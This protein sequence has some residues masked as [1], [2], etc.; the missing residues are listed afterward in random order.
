M[1]SR[2]LLDLLED[3]DWHS[4]T[5]LAE[6]LGT[7]LDELTEVCEAASKADLIE[8]DVKAGKV[9]ICQK[10]L[11]LMKSLEEEAEAEWDMLAT[12][13]VIVP[14]K[15]SFKIQDLSIQNETDYDLEIEMRFDEKLREIVILKM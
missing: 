9:R 13:T 15:K 14:A 7:T 5:G 6:A 2:S 3:G 12:G 8:Y 11:G 10:L 1:A 4:L